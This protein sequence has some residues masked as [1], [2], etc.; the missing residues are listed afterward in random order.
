MEYYFEDIKKNILSL[1][2][3]A[4]STIF[5]AVAWITDFDII[6]AITRKAREGIKVELVVNHDDTFD[7]KRESFLQFTHYGGKLFLY[8]GEG[9][10]HNKFCVIDLSTTITGSFNWTYSAS[11]MHQENIIVIK[12]DSLM[13]MGFA[14]QFLKLKSQS[15]PF[16]NDRL[17]RTN[18]DVQ[19]YQI[20]SIQWQCNPEYNQ[21][22]D[23]NTII[24]SDFYYATVKIKGQDKIGL[25]L[26]LFDEQLVL[27][28][29][30]LGYFSNSVLHSGGE[31]IFICLDSSLKSYSLEIG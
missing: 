3:E 18:N 15:L 13:A 1:I 6:Q 10:M 31:C 5:C 28:D 25:C 24:V 16:T 8:Q 9:L 26:F 23:G 12:E 27:P 20:E 30:L 29:R 22:D 11:R 2:D 7:L 19:F 4:K 17:I 21:D 14:K